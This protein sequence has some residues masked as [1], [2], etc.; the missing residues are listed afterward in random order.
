MPRAAVVP[1]E[2]ALRTVL[3][4]YIVVGGALGL[5]WA[6]ATA[7][8]AEADAD[9]PAVRNLYTTEG[10]APNLLALQQRLC[11]SQA[12]MSAATL[13]NTAVDVFERHPRDSDAALQELADLRKTLIN[14]QNGDY[15]W[16]I[17]REGR[18]AFT[19]YRIRASMHRGLVNVPMTDAQREI[20]KKCTRGRCSL[21]RINDYLFSQTNLTDKRCGVL[22]YPWYDPRTQT[23]VRKRN[24]VYRWSDDLLIGS[25]YTA[26]VLNVSPSRPTVWG[27]M[28]MYALFLVALFVCP[29]L[30]EPTA[31]RSYYWYSAAAFSGLVL[32]YG[33]LHAR[34]AMHSALEDTVN[35]Q[36]DN[37]YA[38]K[39][40][41]WII[42]QV[43]VLSLAF[44]FFFHFYPNAHVHQS[45]YFDVTKL[46]IFNVVL[47]LGSGLL[48]VVRRQHP[49]LNALFTTAL[50]LALLC[51]LW[52][53]WQLYTY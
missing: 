11:Q 44:L 36:F 39:N 45:D 7:D 42:A 16:V 24:V 22:S 19:E 1:A 13:V 8:D 23:T 12:C 30:S 43:A 5:R 4:A 17:G 51:M 10:V 26:D 47:C 28:G 41:A 6:L 15:V 35:D 38:W 18:G 52:M 3:L 49:R 2:T 50:N 14:P 46:L 9:A 25:G 21:K 40:S 29:A 34:Y 37:Y 48:Y 32:V 33:T 31:P 27:V 20:N 53:F